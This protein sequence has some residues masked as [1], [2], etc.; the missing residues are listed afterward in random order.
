MCGLLSH[1][2][3]ENKPLGEVLKAI[4][5]RAITGFSLR[6]R[7]HESIS[8]FNEYDQL[9]PL[10]TRSIRQGTDHLLVFD[11]TVDPTLPQKIFK[12]FANGLK[13]FYGLDQSQ[14]FHALQEINI[15]VERE[16]AP[17]LERDSD[18][19]VP[20]EIPG[21]FLLNWLSDGEQ[22]FLGRMALLTMLD[23]EDSL[24]VLDEPEVHF[25][26]YWKREVVNLLDVAMRSHSNHLL[27]TT[28]SSI[29][30]SDVTDNQ[31]TVLLKNDAGITTQ[32]RSGI[33]TLGADPGEIMSV[34]FQADV[35]SGRRSTD[36]LTFAIAEGDHK[37]VTGLLEQVGPGMWR[38][39]LRQ[40]LEELNATRD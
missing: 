13:L 19:P 26:D 21:L 24:I 31:I 32:R 18:E 36:L 3:S 30:L 4:N 34:T 14:M 8:R 9:K 12:E 5:I 6:F 33:K 22:S 28:H 38:F 35:P 15:V 10:A 37:K 27:I 11:L 25:N 29:L 20:D 2:V 40:R 39:R 17:V 23:T 1:L 16:P 7:L